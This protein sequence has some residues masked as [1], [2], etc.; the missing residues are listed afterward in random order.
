LIHSHNKAVAI[1]GFGTLG[2][3]IE[4]WATLS[5]PLNKG[6]ISTKDSGI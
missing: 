6:P 1:P 3:H 2:P 4:K 5:N